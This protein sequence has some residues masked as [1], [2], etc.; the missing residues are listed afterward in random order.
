MPKD[1][2][3]NLSIEKLQIIENTSIIELSQKELSQRIAGF[4]YRSNL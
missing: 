2:F 4:N 1:I 3:I